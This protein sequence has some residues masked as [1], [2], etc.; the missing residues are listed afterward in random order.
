MTSIVFLHGFLGAT[1]DWAPVIERL[2][3]VRCNSL[4]LPTVSSWDDAVQAMLH[5][6][7]RSSVL[8]GYS[9]GARLALGCVLAQP[10]RFAGLLFVSGN[11]GLP[12]NERRKR[13]IRDEQVAQRLV[14]EQLDDF[15]AAWYQQPVFADV[16]EKVRRNWIHERRSLNPCRQAAMLRGLTIAG[17]PDYWP[18][19]AE[20][21]VPTLVIVGERDAKYREIAVRM[22]MQ[23]ACIDRKLIDKSGHAVLREQPQQLAISIAQFV[24]QSLEIGS[25]GN[26]HE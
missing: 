24:S 17:Q 20:L 11:P 21:T 14:D 5:T 7:P 4:A 18:R 6:L 22:E 8:V 15:L 1:S 23:A 2:S 12:E 19:L 26:D 10:N 9:M 13:R 16:P 3:K 25:T